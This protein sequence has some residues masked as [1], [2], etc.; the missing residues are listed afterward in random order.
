MP[1]SIRKPQPLRP[2]SVSSSVQAAIRTQK[3][4]RR[5]V[6][7]LVLK[8]VKSKIKARLVSDKNPFSGL[9]TAVF[10]LC[11]HMVESVKG[12]V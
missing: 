12:T 7:L 4:N 11:T 10:S 6:F 3:L 9:Y 2:Y 5:C 1:W 8:A